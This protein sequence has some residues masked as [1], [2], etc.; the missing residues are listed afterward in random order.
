MKKSQVKLGDFFFD[1][2]MKMMDNEMKPMIIKVKVFPSCKKE[3]VVR[4]SMDTFMVCVREKPKRREATRAAV[5]VLAGY[6]DVLA[7][8]TKLIKGTQQPNKIF[9]IL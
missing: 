4:R 6:L 1:F 3:F 8:K 7:P 2:E 9:K 5:L